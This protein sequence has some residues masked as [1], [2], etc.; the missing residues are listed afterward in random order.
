MEEV[1]D[2][3]HNFVGLASASPGAD[4]L[5]HETCDELGLTST[6]CLPMPEKDYAVS[7]FE[8]LDSWRTRFLDLVEVKKHPILTLSDRKGL[9]RW[10][11]DRR[12]DAWERG[13][14]WV[15]EMALA[16]GA[17][18]MTLVALWDGKARG[19]APGGTAQVVSL[20]RDSG[21]FRIHQIDS[22][23]LVT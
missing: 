2:D 11:G 17:D 12:V 1:L 10:L 8:N 21:A 9:P 14:A 13:N 16:S 22:N 3:D 15:M 23:Q 7:A 18:R 5:W 19:D 4:I 6:V 20:A